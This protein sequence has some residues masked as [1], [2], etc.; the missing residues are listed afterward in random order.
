ML[1]PAELIKSTKIRVQNA[2]DAVA[3]QEEIVARMNLTGD[4]SVSHEKLLRTFRTTLRLFEDHLRDLM[5]RR[6]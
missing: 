2:R 5:P 3:R 1:A 4:Y 6:R